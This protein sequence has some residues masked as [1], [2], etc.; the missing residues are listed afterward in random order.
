MYSKYTIKLKFI[1]GT[2]VEPTMLRPKRYLFLI[3]SGNHD[4]Y[5]Y[6]F[7]KGEI[8]NFRMRVIL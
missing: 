5:Y 3:K 1:E 7:A 4:C 8:L 6:Y 2:K